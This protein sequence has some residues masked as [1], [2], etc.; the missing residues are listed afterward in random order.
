[1]YLENSGGNLSLPYVPWME[2]NFIFFGM[3]N[4]KYLKKI[5][6]ECGIRLCLIGRLMECVRHVEAIYPRYMDRSVPAT[7]RPPSHNITHYYYRK[8]WGQ[9]LPLRLCVVV[10][11]LFFFAMFSLTFNKKLI[12]YDLILSI[13]HFYL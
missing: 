10:L 6:L 12:K 9:A 1:M 2:E 3:K 5:I 8:R 13:I 7:I 11:C 4:I